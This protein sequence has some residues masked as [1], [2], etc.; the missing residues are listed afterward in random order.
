[1]KKG[2]YIAGKLFKQGDIRQRLY[3]EEILKKKY[4]M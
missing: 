4:P 1:M 2:I 3:E